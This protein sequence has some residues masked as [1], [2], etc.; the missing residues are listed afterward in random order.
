MAY[1]RNFLRLILRT[2]R[3]LPM[4][5]F[6][7]NSLQ[8]NLH[9]DNN[10]QD[11]ILLAKKTAAGRRALLMCQPIRHHVTPLLCFNLLSNT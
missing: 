3:G 1:I 8:D 9:N 11:D 6:I 7:P 5:S 10:T 4:T 2:F